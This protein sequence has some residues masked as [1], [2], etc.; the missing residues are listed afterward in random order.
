VTHSNP[1]ENIKSLPK[2]G[3]YDPG[4]FPTLPP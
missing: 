1:N 2:W 3:I 4:K